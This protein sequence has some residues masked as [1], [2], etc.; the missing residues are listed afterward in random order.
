MAVYYFLTAG[1]EPGFLVKNK[2]KEDEG[3][4]ESGVSLA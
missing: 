2:E 4:E 3:D 1:D